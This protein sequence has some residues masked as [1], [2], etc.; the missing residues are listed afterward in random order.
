MEKLLLLFKVE[1]Y[2]NLYR[3]ARSRLSRRFKLL[4]GL[5]VIEVQA[6]SDIRIAD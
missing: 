1:R 2:P 6:N 5:G 4:C 3:H